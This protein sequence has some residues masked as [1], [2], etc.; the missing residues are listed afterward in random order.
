MDC[1]FTSVSPCKT[2]CKLRVTQCA[3]LTF[4]IIDLCFHYGDEGFDRPRHSSSRL[5]TIPPNFR[6]VFLLSPLHSTPLSPLIGLRHLLFTSFIMSLLD[7]M[8]TWRRPLPG[9]TWAPSLNCFLP[10][11]TRKNVYSRLGSVE[12]RNGAGPCSASSMDLEDGLRLVSERAGKQ[13][14]RGL[15]GPWK[16]RKRGPA[17]AAIFDRS[18]DG[19][20]RP[21][22]RGGKKQLSDGGRR[23]RRHVDVD[24]TPSRLMTK[25]M[26]SRWRRPAR[27]NKRENWREQAANCCRKRRK[28]EM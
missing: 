5:F 14:C 3:C 18:P 19:Y 12:N 9:Q 20:I 8:S 26:N 1:V 11:L 6:S 2:D 17:P 4:T 23:G 7:V 27:E 13:C 16:R 15:R 28:R 25:E 10:P 22:V 24:T 21:G